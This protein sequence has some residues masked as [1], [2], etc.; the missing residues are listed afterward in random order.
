MKLYLSHTK[1]FRSFVAV[2][3]ALWPFRICRAALDG[4]L[5]ELRHTLDAPIY[6]GPER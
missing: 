6:I 2:R 4:Y 1:E 3:R 5:S